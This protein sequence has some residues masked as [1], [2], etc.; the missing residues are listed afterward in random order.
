MPRYPLYLAGRFVDAA[1]GQ[2]FPTENP[3]TLEPWADI[4]RAGP[5]DV[6]A[7]VAGG[8]AALAG[9]WGRLKPAGRAALLR[10][11]ADGR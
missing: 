4:A 1:G 8:Q 11:L 10:K 9:D 5:A 3:Y 2:T 6:D 7:A